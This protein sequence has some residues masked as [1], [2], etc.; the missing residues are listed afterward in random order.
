MNK[1]AYTEVLTKLADKVMME[2]RVYE[3]QRA[4]GLFEIVRS[5]KN[6]L[7]DEEWDLVLSKLM[8]GPTD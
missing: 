5:A 3:R 7:T 6:N 1:E 4:A 2:T 8:G